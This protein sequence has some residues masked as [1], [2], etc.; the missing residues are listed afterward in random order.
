MT[1][2]LNF[3][4][5]PPSKLVTSFFMVG[6]L[7]YFIGSIIFLK[8]DFLNIYYLAPEAVGFVHIF[9][10]GFMMSII[11]GAL[12]QL[13]SVILEIPLFSDTL[14]F[15]HLALFVIGVIPFL[16]SFLHNGL[17]EFLGYGSL[18]LYLSFL[19]YIANILLSIK[20]IKKLEL[21][22]Y[23]IL[24]IHLILFLGVTYGLLASLGLVHPNLGYDTVSLAHSHIVLV[25][26]GFAG[27]LMAII[28]TILIPMF[29]LSH[30]FNKNISNYLLFGFI[31]ASLCAVFEWF[32]LSQILMIATIFL[33]T[34]QLYDIFRKRMRK[35]LDIYAL[36][37]ITSGV[38]L[39]LLALLIPFLYE[40]K[41]IKLFLIFLFF[42]FISSF[43]VGHI[44]KIVPFL[45]WNEKFAP[46]VGKQK[47]PMLADMIHDKASYGEFGTKIATILFLTLGV[48][49]TSTL[50]IAIGKIMF[51]VNALLVVANVIYIFKYKG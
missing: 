15:A 1:G 21:K 37:M 51:L 25:L 10:L 39:S 3:T 24:S 23:F 35:H 16:G 17:F 11:F 41:M 20:Q 28:A 31:S 5:A 27:G 19:L 36:D 46:L 26:F 7:F 12:Y 34:F 48:L 44:Y 42:G 8:I 14:A 2:G 45:V 40:E 30:N 38:F 47:V 22:A 6:T 18:L 43:V 33:F 4:F 29:M 9:L 50:L 13:I 32:T 49:T